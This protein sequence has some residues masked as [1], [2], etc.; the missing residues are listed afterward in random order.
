M[1]ASKDREKRRKENEAKRSS[2]FVP[3]QIK[4]NKANTV[5]EDYAYDLF[6]VFL[7]EA[8]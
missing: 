6:F 4:G 1:K 2:K 8:Y 3:P 7:M 5:T